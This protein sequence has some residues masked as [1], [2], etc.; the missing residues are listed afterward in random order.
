MFIVSN[1]W[2]LNLQHVLP[3]KLLRNRKRKERKKK[4][5][6]FDSSKIQKEYPKIFKN[7]CGSNV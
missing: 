2:T 5:L 6:A 3:G 7:M 4:N 1:L